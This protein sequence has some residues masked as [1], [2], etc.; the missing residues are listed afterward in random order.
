MD[1]Q[2]HMENQTPT[3]YSKDLLSLIHAD[4]NQI[5]LMVA[6]MGFSLTGVVVSWSLK[7][8]AIDIIEIVERTRQTS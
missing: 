6:I 2:Q 3:R 5:Q 8:V 1:T 4:A 7:R